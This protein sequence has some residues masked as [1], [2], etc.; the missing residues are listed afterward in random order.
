MRVPVEVRAREDGPGYPAACPT[1]QGCH[2][3]GRSIGEAIDD[4]RDVARTL[5]EITREDGTPIRDGDQA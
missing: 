3:E 4:L 5:L 2:A 1:I